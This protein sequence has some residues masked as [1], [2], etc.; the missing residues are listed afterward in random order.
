MLVPR[1]QAAHLGKRLRRQKR[2][3]VF[4]NGVFDLVHR[5]HIDY[6][7]KARALGDCLI[8]GMNS[9]SSVR[10]LKGSGR[11]LQVQA[12][13]AAILL[14]L[15]S[16]DFVIIFSEPTPDKLIEE[17]RPDVLVKGADYKLSEIAGA[18]F[19]RDHGGTV[20]RIRLT[21]GRSSS[22]LLEKLK[23]L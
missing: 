5:G 7:T 3:I 23:R 19:V 14:A 20:R 9:D 22:R 15:R 13:R 17:I 10:K 12:D 16:V 4:T 21:R 18:R 6:L 11:P 8:I 2:R 1:K